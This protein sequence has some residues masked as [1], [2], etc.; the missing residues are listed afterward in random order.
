[1]TISELTIEPFKPGEPGTHVQ[2][3]LS[4]IQ[5]ADVAVEV[6]PFGT[7]IEGS[8]E[9]VLEVVHQVLRRA[10]EAGATRVT[11]QVVEND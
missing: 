5:D 2:A 7:T 3:A 1:M 8:R 11:L 4:I 6:G 9:T 10:F